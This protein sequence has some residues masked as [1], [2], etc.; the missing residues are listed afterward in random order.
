MESNLNILK[1]KQEVVESEAELRAVEEMLNENCSVKSEALKS[2]SSISKKSK[3]EIVND[4]LNKIPAR[5]DSQSKIQQ[6]TFHLRPSAPEFV[7]QTTA[8]FANYMVKKDLLL[9]RVTK[10]NDRPEQFYTWKRSFRDICT[11]IETNDREELDLP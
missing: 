9:S 11:E 8:N 6:E 1:C 5:P 2:I 3:S 4:Y 10:F 7:P